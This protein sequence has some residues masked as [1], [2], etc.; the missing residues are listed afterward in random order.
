MRVKISLLCAPIICS[1]VG[2]PQ[3]ACAAETSTNEVLALKAEVERLKGL[4]PDQAHAMKDVGYHFAN[5]WFAGEKKNWPLAEFYL[6][7]TRSHLRWAVRIIPVR[8]DPQGREVHLTDILDAVEKSSMKQL[9]DTIGSKDSG[10]FTKAYREMMESCYACHV[11]SGKPY[12]RLQ[13][14]KQPEAPIIDFEPQP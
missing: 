8:K 4:V 1:A 2:L 14:P 12:L 13:V 5:L 10:Q 3:I 6:G 11:A 9:G 7:E